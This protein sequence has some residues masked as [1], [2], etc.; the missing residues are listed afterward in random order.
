MSEKMGRDLPPIPLTVEPPNWG[1][2]PISECGE[3]LVTLTPIPGRLYI[4][5]MYFEQKIPGAS[6]TISARQGV[7][8]RLERAAASLPPGLALVVFDV[9]R[10]LAVQ[11]F[12]YDSYREMLRLQHPDFDDDKLTTL[13]HQYVA[14]PNADPKCP[15]PHR[16]G[17]AADAYLISADGEPLPMGTAPDEATPASA[18]RWFEERPT[19]PFTENRRL[20]HHAM[21]SAGFANYPGEWW[22]YDY[23]NQRWANLIGTPHALYGIPD[24]TEYYL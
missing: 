1:R 5:P 16:T 22:H 12:L 6:R 23:G 19:A 20:L 10:P 14:S 2:L 3:P 18:T 15:P 17:G 7:A 8:E 11:R 9:Y 4:R 24:E 13:L 21:T